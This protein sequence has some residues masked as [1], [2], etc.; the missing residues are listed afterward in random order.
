MAT[1]IKYA[2]P[3]VSDGGEAIRV[4]FTNEDGTEEMHLDM[5]PDEVGKF[6]QNLEAA[7]QLAAKKRG[8]AHSS[9]RHH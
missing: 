1:V 4:I 2:T 3:Q 7:A 9:V 8:E 5:N 6:I